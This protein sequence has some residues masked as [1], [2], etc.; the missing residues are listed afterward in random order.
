MIQNKKLIKSKVVA[1]FGDD[2]LIHDF[3]EPLQLLPHGVIFV[4]F[5][6]FSRILLRV[7]VIGGLVIL[8]SKDFSVEIHSLARSLLLGPT[9][10]LFDFILQILVVLSRDLEF[11]LQLQDLGKH[12]L[13]DEFVLALETVQFFP[14]DLHHINILIVE[15]IVLVLQFALFFRQGFVLLF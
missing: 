4:F 6:L 3:L 15:L 8:L 14:I 10:Q 13:L 12:L 5:M 1:F 9:S 7:A 2:L 11:P